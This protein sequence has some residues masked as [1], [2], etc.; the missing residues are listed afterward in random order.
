MFFTDPARR[1]VAETHE[2]LELVLQADVRVFNRHRL[3]ADEVGAEDG[4]VAV[5]DVAVHDAEMLFP[6]LRFDRR[7]VGGD[8]GY[9]W[10]RHHKTVA[11]ICWAGTVASFAGV[12]CPPAPTFKV[13]RAGSWVAN[14]SFDSG[15]NTSASA[16]PASK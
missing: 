10:R 4:F 6:E 7:G 15:Q 9:C 3:R 5:A 11:D 12:V 8:T 13:R 16:Q 1:I 2:V 14:A